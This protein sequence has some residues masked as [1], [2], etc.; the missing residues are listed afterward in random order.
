MSRAHQKRGTKATER[1]CELREP[2]FRELELALLCTSLSVRLFRKERLQVLPES[3]LRSKYVVSLLF[4]LLLRP[5]RRCFFRSKPQT[6]HHGTE[7]DKL[8]PLLVRHR[9]C[10]KPLTQ[11]KEHRGRPFP[12]SEGYQ[13]PGLQIM[14]LGCV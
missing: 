14:G 11:A 5:M 2:A 13:R 7:L 3:L 10:K 1:S 6:N 8:Q 12:G 4:L 9:A